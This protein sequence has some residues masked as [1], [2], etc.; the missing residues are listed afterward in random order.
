MPRLAPLAAVCFAVIGLMMP[1]E[2]SALPTLFGGQL[3]YTGGDVTID[4]LHSNTAF[5]EVLQL[6]S[7]LTVLDI[8]DGTQVGSRITITAQQLADMG[9]G[10]GDELQFGIRVLDTGQTFVLGSG[11]K[12]SDGL[13]HAYVRTGHDNVFYYVG[14]EDFYG[15]GDRDYNDTIFR[16][17]GGTTTAAEVAI[18]DPFGSDLEVAEPSLLLLLLPGLGLLGLKR[19]RGSSREENR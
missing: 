10:V 7:A 14:F 2:A 4:V 16:F 18:A 9:I 17:S 6:H 12:N 15:G 5:D 8:A 19:R 11:D 13:A 3:Y 1:I